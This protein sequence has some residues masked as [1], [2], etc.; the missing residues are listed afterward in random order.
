M[1]LRSIPDG[2]AA[3][4]NPLLGRAVIPPSMRKKKLFIFQV[5]IPASPRLPLKSLSQNN[6]AVKGGANDDEFVSPPKK[7][8]FNIQKEQQENLT[9]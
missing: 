3:L 2:M 7:A 1:H 5:K 4:K 9:N 6:L 8:L